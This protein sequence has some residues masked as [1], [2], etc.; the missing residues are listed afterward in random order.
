MSSDL[1]LSRF[2]N[3]EVSYL[4]KRKSETIVQGV[5]VDSGMVSWKS[6]V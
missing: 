5:K 4:S 3:G 1:V 6:Q 2:I